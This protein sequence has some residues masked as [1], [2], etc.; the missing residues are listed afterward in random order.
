MSG[1]LSENVTFNDDADIATIYGVRMTGELLRAIAAKELAGK[2]L[3]FV[4]DDGV[5][6]VHR[7]YER[8]EA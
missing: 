4:C 7:D 5:V 3:R 6:T 8:D 2:W 1:P